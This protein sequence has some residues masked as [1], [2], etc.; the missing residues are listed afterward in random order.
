VDGGLAHGLSL[1]TLGSSLLGVYPA[2][3]GKLDVLFF[4]AGQ[5]GTY[6]RLD[7]AAWAALVEAGYQLPEVFAKPW[8]GAGVNAASG[9]H[10]PTDGDHGTF[11]NMLPTNHLY[12][13][14]ADQIALQNIVNPFVQLRFTPHPTLALNL[15]AHWFRLASSNDARYAGT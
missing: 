2:G 5:L 6:N 10:D 8:L 11:F 7:H 13:G 4:G 14:F 15:F 1:V 12:Y 3:P 9:D